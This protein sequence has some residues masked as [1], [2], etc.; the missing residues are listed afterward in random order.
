MREITVTGKAVVTFSKTITGVSDEE[1]REV[2][3]Q[4]AWEFADCNIDECDLG[5][6]TEFVSVNMN[7]E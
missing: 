4:D 1:A 5:E 3:N 2:Q 7:V 6:I